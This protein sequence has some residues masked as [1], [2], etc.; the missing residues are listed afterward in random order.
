MQTEGDSGDCTKAETSSEEDIVHTETS[1]V[2]IVYA[3]RWSRGW[4]AYAACTLHHAGRKT[5]QGCPSA[6]RMIRRM[7]IRKLVA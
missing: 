5:A 4:S 1:L 7:I 2:V 3:G 6:E